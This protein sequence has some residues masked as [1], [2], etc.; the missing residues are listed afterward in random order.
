MLV[1]SHGIVVGMN[2]TLSPRAMV[3]FGWETFKSRGWFFTG[4]YVFAI[5]AYGGASRLIET[6]FGSNAPEPQI[7]VLYGIGVLL[8]FVVNVLSN[9]GMTWFSLKAHDG[10]STVTLH[11]LWHPRPFWTFVGVSILSALCVLGGL[12]LL[13]IPGFIVALMLMFGSYIILEKN[14][15]PVAALQESRRITK[16]HLKSLFVLVLLLT[17]VNILGFLALVVGLAVSIPVS[18]F[19]TVHAYRTLSQVAPQNVA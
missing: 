10:P 9:M 1:R 18:M 16:G 19:A 14:V 15:G 13:I 11:D 4:A 7:G 17:G 8:S 2:T 5:L 12:F 3:R 6:I